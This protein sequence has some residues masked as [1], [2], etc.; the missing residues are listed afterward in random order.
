MALWCGIDTAFEVVSFS[1]WSK[2]GPMIDLPLMV[3][4]V[5]LSW[6]TKSKVTQPAP[7]TVQWLPLLSWA[8]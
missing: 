1:V 8:I 5:S 2:K 3:N 7:S 6:Q 4:E